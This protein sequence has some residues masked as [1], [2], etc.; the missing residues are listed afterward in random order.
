MA[1]LVPKPSNDQN[2]VAT[3]APLL[4]ATPTAELSGASHTLNT[5]G[6]APVVDAN[7]TSRSK[8]V[9]APSSNPN[10]GAA[11]PTKS[12]LVRNH[13]APTR[14]PQDTPT[15]TTNEDDILSPS[16]SSKKLTR[17]QRNRISA[18]KSRQKK[19]A[20]QTALAQ[21]VNDLEQ[22]VSM[23]KQENAR[24]QEKQASVAKQRDIQLA[25]VAAAEAASPVSI[26]ST[27]LTPPPSGSPPLLT[28]E[29][30]KL[31]ARIQVE[32][33][34]QHHLGK[35]G[36][37]ET[38]QHDEHF[39][40]ADD[41]CHGLSGCGQMLTQHQGTFTHDTCS[42]ATTASATHP[43]PSLSGK[44]NVFK[45]ATLETQ[46][47][48]CLSSLPS[49]TGKASNTEAIRED[50]GPRVLPKVSD[51]VGTPGHIQQQKPRQQELQQKSKTTTALNSTLDAK[52]CTPVA[53]AF[54]TALIAPAIQKVLD[55]HHEQQHHH[56]ATSVTTTLHTKAKGSQMKTLNQSRLRAHSKMTP[57]C[58]SLKLK[59]WSYR[60]QR[61]MTSLTSPS[62]SHYQKRLSTKYLALL[63]G[64][65]QQHQQQQLAALVKS[66]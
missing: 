27:S 15:P 40:P 42:G 62:T 6:L 37:Y 14:S 9:V 41:A 1:V 58:K 64:Y 24:L 31:L 44:D 43:S 20:E 53:V 4:P 7:L 65:R 47:K 5:C 59:D 16:P 21:R 61:A 39:L 28:D 48:S 49:R 63:N 29:D 30:M 35:G 66:L 38:Q 10:T 26:S 54:L 45:H 8:A 52:S 13:I 55:R 3:V 22:V 33:E 51:S 2:G 23:L 12:S 50:S 46:Q 60:Y 18:F 17:A 11:S 25:A 32:S 56:S 36:K 34:R 57:S 19:L